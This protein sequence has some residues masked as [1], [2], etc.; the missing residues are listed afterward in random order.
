MP[1]SKRRHLFQAQH[2]PI[3]EI[4]HGTYQKCRSNAHPSTWSSVSVWSPVCEAPWPLCWCY[5]ASALRVDWVDSQ[6]L[7]S[8]QTSLVASR[9]LTLDRVWAGTHRGWILNAE[10]IDD[11]EWRLDLARLWSLSIIISL[12]FI[13]LV[14]FFTKHTFSSRGS[15]E[16][17]KRYLLKYRCS[18]FCNPLGNLDVCTAV[19]LY[20][21]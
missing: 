18:L 5:W 10:T 20:Y 6:D 7:S 21:L 9:L 8:W 13:T 11:T 15:P 3:L 12:I 4:Q 16:I 17:L 1:F 14:L 19:R 2:P